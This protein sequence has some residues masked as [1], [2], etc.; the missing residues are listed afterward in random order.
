MMKDISLRGKSGYT[1]E[2][3]VNK[4]QDWVWD[5]VFSKYILYPQLLDYVENFTGPNIMAMHTMLINKPPDSGKLTSRH[6]WHQVKKNDQ[7]FFTIKYSDHNLFNKPVA[8]IRKPR[9]Y[10]NSLESSCLQMKTTSVTN[11]KWLSKRSQVM[12]LEGFEN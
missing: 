4:I 2:R 9:K 6:P 10:V 3:V 11:N 8:T 7:V 5:D 12:V 1:N